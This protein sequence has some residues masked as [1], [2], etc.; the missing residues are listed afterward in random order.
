MVTDTSKLRA[1]I[2]ERSGIA[3]DEK[4]P[5]MAVLVA[6]AQQTEEIGTRLLRRSGTARAVLASALVAALAAMVSCWATWQLAESRAREEQANWLRQQA[7]PR[8]AA[9]IRSAEGRAG[10]HLAEIGVAKLLAYCSG[11]RSW[12]IE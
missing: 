10:L 3:V 5:I 9:L 8:I 12:R 6:S 2:F 4:D 1:V 11:R 7:D